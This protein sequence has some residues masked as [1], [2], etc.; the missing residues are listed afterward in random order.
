[1]P[2]IDFSLYLVTDRHQTDG[3][4]L[5]DVLRESLA[6]G[7][8]AVQLREKDLPTVDLLALVREV[9]PLTR[10]AGRP[11]LINDRV[12]VVLATGADGV[13]LRSQSLPVHVARGLLGPSMLVGVS[14]HSAAEV[15][16]AEA[17]G[18]DF[19]ALGPIYA[20][21]SK[22]PYGAPLG[23]APLRDAARRCRI[24][25]FAIGGVTAA[26]VPELRAAGAA[27]V[28]VISA[29]LRGGAVSAATQALLQQLRGPI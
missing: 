8:E 9:L 5:T 23:L 25:I 29:V 28:A 10:A 24:P 26:R 3:R 20:T 16:T 19:V 7:A 13:H 15:V 11:L 18:A 1:M 22:Q 14:T 2:R 27:G 12:D 4:S 21:P 6:A 17:E